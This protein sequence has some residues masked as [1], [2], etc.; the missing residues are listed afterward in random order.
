MEKGTLIKL[1]AP[2]LLLVIAGIFF[3]IKAFTNSSVVL[4]VVGGLLIGLGIVHITL[5]KKL[6]KTDK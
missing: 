2:Y 5:F 6:S 4:G 1:Y 3:I